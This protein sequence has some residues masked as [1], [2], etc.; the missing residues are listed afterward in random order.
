MLLGRTTELGYLNNYYD[1]DGSQ[2]LIVYGQKHIGKTALVREFMKDRPGC[3]YLAK[4]CSEREQAYQWG[5]QLAHDG[6]IVE[7]FPTFQEI[8]EKISRRA[9]GKKVLVIDEFQNIVRASDAFMKDLV[10]FVHSQW[11][12][13]NVMVILISSSIGWIE[14]SMIN[15]I[16]EA[17]YELS[18]LLKIK[19]MPFSDIVERFP[20]FRI[21]ECVEAYAILGGI[22]G[23]WNQ[24]DDRLTI[25]QNICRNIL[26][27]NSF[28]F[29]EGERILTEQLR[30]PG[31]YNTIM[32]SIAAGNHKLN[33]LY[34]H[35]E[36]SRAK[37]SVYLKN[38]I[39]LELV[40]KV[41][42]YDTA[43]KE[44]V[45]KGIYRISHPFVDFY[46]TYMYPHLSDLQML[47]VGEFYNHYIMRDFRR[48][49]AGYFKLVCRQHLTRL[50][51]RNRLPIACGAI[52]EWIGKAGT[53]D[54]IAQDQEG[55]TLIGLC[56]WEKPMTYEDYEN[57]LL[58]AKK[59][60]ISADYI[61]MYT[62]FRFDE[63]LNLEAKVKSN[64][65]LVQIS[66]L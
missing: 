64:L 45:Q 41:F 56:N 2:I 3:Y 36:F 40:E 59:A 12:R 34:L 48:Y 33:D 16:G 47:S 9:T 39:E 52:G 49:V 44:N 55:R 38:L 4:A 13:D 6:Y 21:E 53:L 30:E 10:A 25:Q 23:L 57:L 22:P 63:K 8:F 29:E 27:G 62:A 65:K 5:R 19:E 32:A 7:K 24:F 17:A 35:T 14:N 60:K 11:N 26:D 58:Y 50:G 51:E 1:R 42:S 31:V 66:D 37:I 15:R 46:Y 28:L 61:Y 43:G 20:N 54:I 18:G